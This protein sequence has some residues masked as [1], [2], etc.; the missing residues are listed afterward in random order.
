MPTL[1]MLSTAKL[2]PMDILVVFL[3]AIPK[4]AFIHHW[5]SSFL[6][7]FAKHK[8]QGELAGED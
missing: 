6:K 7:L 5:P 4:T 2:G 8:V 1:S 3:R